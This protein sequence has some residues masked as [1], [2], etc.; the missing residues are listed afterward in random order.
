MSRAGF[1]I[2]NMQVDGIASPFTPITP[3]PIA[4]PYLDT[5]LYDR[6]ELVRGATGLLS[7]TG[8]SSATLDPDP[9]SQGGDFALS[10]FASVGRRDLYRGGVDLHR[11]PPMEGCELR[12][13]GLYHTGD[14]WRVRA[15]DDRLLL[16]E[17]WRWMLVRRLCCVSPMSGRILIRAGRP[18]AA[19]RVIIATIGWLD[20]PRSTNLATT[21]ARWD[22]TEN[23]ADITLEQQIGRDWKLVA[24]LGSAQTLSD[25]RAYFLGRGVPDRAGN[26][27]S[28]WFFDADGR[29][30]QWTY[31]AHL[32]GRLRAVLAVSTCSCSA[33][34]A[35]ISRMMSEVQSGG[36]APLMLDGVDTNIFTFTASVPN[37][38]AA[39]EPSS[40]PRRRRWT[41]SSEA[42]AC[43]SPTRFM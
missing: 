32:D 5:Y 37:R 20:M 7:A 27:R 34:M 3:S 14:S 24:A 21:W 9:Q 42:S 30:D 1:V 25:P 4:S 36:I 6:I 39:R 11:L 16:P 12:L 10:G 18:M 22:K 40:T 31:D 26:G 23:R 41:A 38:H 13:I 2:T 17:C 29:H 35:T 19:C 28:F 8:D 43:H 15:S 33:S